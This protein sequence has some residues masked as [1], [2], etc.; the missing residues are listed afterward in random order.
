LRVSSEELFSRPG[1]FSI[2]FGFDSEKLQSPLQLE[3]EIEVRHSGT[4]IVA[5]IISGLPKTFEGSVSSDLSGVNSKLQSEL[6]MTFWDWPLENSRL[7]VKANTNWLEHTG[8]I[9]VLS[10]GGKDGP[11]LSWEL[12]EEFQEVDFRALKPL[13][14]PKD[15]FPHSPYHTYSYIILRIGN[16][17]NEFPVVGHLVD[18]RQSKRRVFGKIVDLDDPDAWPY[19]L[20]KGAHFKEQPTSDKFLIRKG[21]LWEGFSHSEPDC[22]G[23][24]RR[25]QHER[26]TSAVPTR[27]WFGHKGEEFIVN[28]FHLD[29]YGWKVRFE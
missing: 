24:I 27:A 12:T 17:E 1:S 5:R 18:S 28:W 3:A 13:K 11:R 6:S 29:E 19:F 7:E 21:R 23:T 26:Y 22:S 9:E 20:W 8:K 10:G 16:E 2:V 4:P 15:G 14:L 25:V